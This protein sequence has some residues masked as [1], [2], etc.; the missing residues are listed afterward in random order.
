MTARRVHSWNRARFEATDDVNP[1]EQFGS[2]IDVFLVFACGLIAALLSTTPA[3]P[4]W[5]TNSPDGSPVLQSVE[6]GR[7]LP[8]LPKS[9]AGSG[10]GLKPM[11]QVFQDPETGKFFLIKSQPSTTSAA[12][13]DEVGQ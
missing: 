4:A 5:N 8:K 1:M 13:D 10:T 11:G 3:V 7:E 2:L 12:T 6:R 9:L